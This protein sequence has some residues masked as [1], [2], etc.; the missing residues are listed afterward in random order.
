MKLLE[1][2]LETQNTTKT[3]T[4]RGPNPQ[5]NHHPTAPSTSNSPHPKKKKKNQPQQPAAP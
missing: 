4:K 2:S 3:P 5:T 1:I